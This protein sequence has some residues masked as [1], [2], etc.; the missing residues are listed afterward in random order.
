MS[1]SGADQARLLFSVDLRRCHPHHLYMVLCSPI[2]VFFHEKA[3]IDPF[4][5]LDLVI[6]LGQFGK[7]KKCANSL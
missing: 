4:A 5:E 3:T 2:S 1:N 6:K 7:F